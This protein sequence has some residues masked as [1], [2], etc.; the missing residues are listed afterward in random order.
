MHFFS[1]PRKLFSFVSANKLTSCS[2]IV[3]HLRSSKLSAFHF[4]PRQA[5]I[6]GAILLLD[7]KDEGATG[8]NI[9]PMFAAVMKVAFQPLEQKKRKSCVNLVIE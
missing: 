6:S 2:N 7:S 8:K 1:I 3:Y 9:N 4:Y 5:F